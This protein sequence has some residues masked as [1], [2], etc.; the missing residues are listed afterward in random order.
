MKQSLLALRAP[1]VF[2]G[3]LSLVLL[4]IQP[5]GYKVTMDE[6]VLAATSLRM[7]EYKE[8]MTTVR[9]HDLQGVY[10]QLDAYVDKRPYFFPF[11]VSLL[12]DLT[13]YRSSNGFLLNILLTPI[14]LSLTYLVGSWLW[15][16]YGGYISCVLF[17]SVPLVSMN[18][19]GGGFELLNLVMVLITTIAARVYFHHPTLRNQSI[20]ILL[21]LLLAQTRYESS[22]YILAVAGVIFCRWVI[23]RKIKISLVLIMAPL[24][25]IPFALQQ[26]IF[27]DYPG[28]WQ[29]RDGAEQ[30]FSLS[31][32]SGNLIS[33]KNYFF[34]VFDDQQPN[35]LLLSLLFCLSPFVALSLFRVF[36]LRIIKSKNEALFVVP[37]LIVIL[38]NFCLLMSYHW[39]QMDEIVVTRIA[40]PFILLQVFVSVFALSLF[41]A[42]KW[43]GKAIVLL[44]AFYFLCFTLPTAGRSDFLQRVPGQHRALWLLDNLDEYR[45]ESILVVSNMPLVT[46]AEKIPSISQRT[47]KKSKAQLAMHH[48][49]GTFSEIL[50]VYTLSNKSSEDGTHKPATPVLKDFKLKTLV[51]TTMGTHGLIRI[52]RLEGVVWLEGEQR[53]VD[54]SGYQDL[55]EGVEKLSFFAQTLP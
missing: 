3:L 13:G 50:F 44:T 15:A 43:F 47:A 52:A 29:L 35:S 28:L 1:I 51:E 55:G 26:T 8:V 33:A 12:H 9:S 11:L 32:V 22:L 27:N 21:G 31:F 49:V 10:T 41:S 54:L 24:F 36:R 45:G 5:I 37:F 17:S 16:R 34:N 39:G 18:S 53:E 40:M 48:E 4:C 14:V 46:I 7:H 23:D 25:M 6:P 20:L 38:A 30:P 19:T 42:R 2:V